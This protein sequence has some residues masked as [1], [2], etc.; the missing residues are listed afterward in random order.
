VNPFITH[1]AS[2]D[3]DC[4]GGDCGDQVRLPWALLLG[5]SLALIGVL[6]WVVKAYLLLAFI[7]AY[8]VL[9]PGLFFALSK[10]VRMGLSTIYGL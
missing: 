9:L 3:P 4:D 7:G 8:F 6:G 2:S 5:V 10:V 1:I